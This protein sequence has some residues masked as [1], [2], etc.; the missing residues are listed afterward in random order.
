MVKD[1]KKCGRTECT[2]VWNDWTD[3]WMD[4]AKSIS[5]LLHRGMDSKR[6]D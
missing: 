1:I 2:D 3:G 6:L 4:K 5:F